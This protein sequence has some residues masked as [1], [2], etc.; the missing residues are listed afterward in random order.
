MKQ[1]TP[2]SLHKCF[3]VNLNLAFKEFKG[4]NKSIS[5]TSFSI[6][7]KYLVEFHCFPTNT[8]YLK[9]I[10][11]C[12]WNLSYLQWVAATGYIQ[13]TFVSYRKMLLGFPL[14]SVRHDDAGGVALLTQRGPG[15]WNVQSWMFG[16]QVF[17]TRPGSGCVLEAPHCASELHSTP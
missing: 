2:L 11:W 3:K 8:V 15:F 9:V 16:S 6:F 5:D 17:S 12:F 14:L 4:L 1:C 7:L 13:G 10:I